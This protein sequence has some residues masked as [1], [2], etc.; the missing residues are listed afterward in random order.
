MNRKN[1]TKR[2]L[3]LCVS[4]IALCS[5]A[6]CGSKGDKIYQDVLQRYVVAMDEDWDA[7]M[8]RSADMCYLY[9]MKADAED[10]IGYAFYD[11][12]GSGI[13][14]LLMGEVS[15]GT[16]YKGT[17]YDMYALV[18]GNVV[19]VLSCGENQRYY[20]CEDN[21]IELVSAN[22]TE[23]K[24]NLYYEFDGVTGTLH[25]K[26]AII[27]DANY[28]EDNPW[29]YTFGS[30][31]SSDYSETTEREAREIIDSYVHKDYDVTPFSK[32]D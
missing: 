5:F 26:E 1:I 15:P 10:D 20:L 31:E 24:Y 12:D 3:L 21:R 28:S 30:L 19:S 27:Y 7:E 32:Y 8:L 25:A 16:L 11:V 6:G 4:G 13:P 9:A 18:D 14:E 22:G 29:F 17:I 23:Y 2:L